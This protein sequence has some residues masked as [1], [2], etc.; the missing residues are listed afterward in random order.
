VLPIKTLS[1]V[2]RP[3]REKL[4]LFLVFGVGTFAAVASIV[5]LHTIYTY[6]EAADPFKESL[7]INLWSMIE[8]CIAIS[9]ASV[10][11]LKPIFSAGQRQ[12]SRALHS[13]DGDA[14][15]RTGGGNGNGRSWSRHFHL[16]TTL[17]STST[18]S[19]SMGTEIGSNPDADTEMGHIGRST[20]DPSGPGAPERP[21]GVVP[22]G[23]ESAL[24]PVSE[25]HVAGTSGAE[26]ATTE[27]SML[28][29]TPLSPRER[30]RGV[31]DEKDAGEV[32]GG[33]S[34]SGS[35]LVLQK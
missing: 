31:I 21:R 6:T 29:F 1:S 15:R 34:S 9:C 24:D 30:A 16:S 32:G 11:A 10:S 33:M 12:R 19:R 25:E 5:R 18:A 8:V 28:V 20:P 2:H 23:P 7:K 17:K 26:S 14:P 27:E 3:R 13:S 35:M 22:G 4:L